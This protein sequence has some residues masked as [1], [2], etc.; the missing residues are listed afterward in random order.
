MMMMLLMI[1]LCLYEKKLIRKNLVFAVVLNVENKNSERSCCVQASCVC[2][3]CGSMWLCVVIQ[4]TGFH[5][6]D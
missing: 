4:Y 3:W 6:D 5:N 2:V 1:N